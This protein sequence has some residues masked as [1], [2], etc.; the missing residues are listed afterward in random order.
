MKGKN[1][2]LMQWSDG[3]GG[4]NEDSL[5]QIIVH[6]SANG[7][8]AINY[9][10]PLLDQIPP[11]LQALP[12]WVTWM[13]ARPLDI[14]KSKPDKIPLNPRNGFPASTTNPRSWGSF[15]LASAFYRSYVGAPHTVR[16]GGTVRSGPICGVGFVLS[17]DD[18][19]VGVDLD[20]CVG[21]DGIIAP[22]A[23]E[24]IEQAVSYTEISP[25]G[26]GV[27]I[28]LK[29]KLPSPGFRRDAAEV[30][31]S[32][33]Y[34][35]VT[36]RAAR[37]TSIAENQSA[38][39]WLWAKFG[40]ERKKESAA[41][42]AGTEP[43]D[44]DASA[45]LQKARASK[46]GAQ[47][48]T[49]YDRGDLSA[50]GGD[51]SRA[52]MALCCMLAF[53]TGKDPAW[54]DR[55]FRASA[56]FRPEKWDK[57]HV[58]GQTYGAA[59]IEQAISRNVETYTPREQK[60]KASPSPAPP[61]PNAAPDG[62]PTIAWMPSA[63]P[64]VL[65]QAEQATLRA[66]AEGHTVQLFQRGRE[67]VHVDRVVTSGIRRGVNRQP[68]ALTIRAV[69]ADG[70]RTHF[71]RVANWIKFDGRK[72]A[73][74]PCAV[75][76]TVGKSYLA[77]PEPWMLPHLAGV[78]TAPTLRSD[79]SILDT[80]GYDP[81]TCLFFD[82]DGTEFAPISKNPSKDDAAVALSRLCSLLSEF[83][84]CDAESRAVALAAVLTALVRRSLCTAPM[85]AFTAPVMASG[86]TLLANIVS[87]MATGRPCDV[88]SY[89]TNEEEAK[90]LL[91]ALL[92]SGALIACFDNIEE[93][94]KGD[95]LNALL[96][97]E[98]FQGRVLGKSEQQTVPAT[99]LWLATGNN[100]VVKGDLSTR[101]LLCRLDPAVERP[102]E[103]QFSLNPHEYIP[104]HRGELVRDGLTVL[105][106]YQAAGCPDVGAKPFGRF[107]AW[108]DMIRN[109]L[110]W[111]GE[112]DPT[113]TLS[114][115]READP[116]RELLGN[117]LA[118]W[119]ETFGNEKLTTA[120]MLFRAASIPAM[121]DAIG[122]VCVNMKTGEV[123][124]RLMGKYLSR[125]EGRIVN[126][127]K[128]QRCGVSHQ[129]TLW[130]VVTTEQT[131]GV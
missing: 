53:W 38:L 41:K 66:N 103:R 4:N 32:A 47:F 98:F 18:P 62:R 16:A 90:K 111:L 45:V 9:L 8:S 86:K 125:Y 112:A 63:L 120:E 99:C 102:E 29:G 3:M 69:S 75:P 88:L 89:T 82:P 56:L 72:G 78:I 64:E 121:I 129:A 54:M 59:T 101:V 6:H 80:P 33:R 76:D 70:L 44:L 23:L 43:A 107:E 96:T 65:R 110:V 123:N 25:S 40:P 31:Q 94:L 15:Q 73:W 14:K 118:T 17:P 105:R 79:G 81:A 131:R 97:S 12:Q 20:V 119:E 24:I 37:Q 57:V 22:W 67:V 91:F 11:E 60:K 61:P 115:V 84:F 77:W 42:P 127:R 114:R 95:A 21:P 128:A 126:G 71:S 124:P 106:A 58:R 113:K 5:G 28:F 83:P 74:E 1:K 85:F 35:T 108:A 39:D 2:P 93:P 7:K 117:V 122:P 19:F 87:M 50:Y 26:T 36:G 48:I 100:L 34:L 49:L 104:R 30:Y 92:R 13:A 51:H 109:P 116:D 52:D 55:L 130:Q 10:P 27:R 46:N 68:G